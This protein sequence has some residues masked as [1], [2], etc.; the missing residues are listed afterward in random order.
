MKNILLLLLIFIGVRSV[1]QNVS[2]LYSGTLVNDSTKKVQNYELALSE[3]RD[4]ITGYSYTTFVINDTFYYSIKRVKGEKN[5]GQLIVEDIKMLVNNFPKAP[6]K[7]VHQINIIPLTA[8]DTMTEFN[9]TWKTTQTKKFY[10][11]SGAVDMKRDN[12]SARLQLISHLA[13]L[14][15][16]PPENPST[17]A[18]ENKPNANSKPN[19]TSLPTTI[20]YTQRQTEIIQR[21][22]VSA[23]SL[24]LSFYD[25]GVVDG[26][27]ISV[28]INNTPVLNHQLLTAHA[29]KK[30]I[31]ITI[32]KGST[33][34]LLLVAENLGTI[35]PNT[36][37]ITI[38]DGTEKYQINF[39]ADLLT[40]AAIILTA[41]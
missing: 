16:L 28:Y 1:A 27:T 6:D 36:G 17:I 5:N 35:P 24:V 37:L 14:K 20:P 33:I 10:S 38:Q 34:T 26:D 41:D 21:L 39:S 30:T 32:P 11:L 25:N 40:N 8:T 15:I 29:V 9:G 23:D 19:S 12:D 13:E 4:K 31:P 18:K 2:G 22:H 7:G 3:Y